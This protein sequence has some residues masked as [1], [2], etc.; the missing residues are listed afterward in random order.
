M[1]TAYKHLE[2]RLKIAELTLAQWA[3]IIAGVAVAIC[4]TMYVSPFGPYVSLFSGVY[5]GG[6]P[7]MTAW[8]ASQAQFD[9]W[10]RVAGAARWR[11]GGHVYQPGAGD[12]QGYVVIEA[13]HDAPRFDDAPQLDMEALWN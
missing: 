1:N 2:A 4:W 9:V 3:G 11:R 10:S 7:A 8:L 12:A 6:I 5:V 13:P